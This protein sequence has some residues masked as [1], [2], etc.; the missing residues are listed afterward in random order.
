[1]NS[2]EL[3]KLIEVIKTLFYEPSSVPEDTLRDG[4]KT[5]KETLDT[6]ES[7]KDQFVIAMFYGHCMP[8]LGEEVPISRKK[9]TNVET[10]LFNLY[11]GLKGTSDEVFMRCIKERK[12]DE[13][14]ENHYSQ[15]ETVYY[16]SYKK[17]SL[18]ISS[19]HSVLL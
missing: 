1:M 8:I 11:K 14:I 3:D 5:F 13:L 6:N 19:M 4:I 10:I 18:K 7:T 2:Q 15:N 17:F 9:K 16:K 12:L